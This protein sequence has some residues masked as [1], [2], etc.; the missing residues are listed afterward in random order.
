MPRIHAAAG[1]TRQ[2]FGLLRNYFGHLT[3][4]RAKRHRDNFNTISNCLPDAV[5][6]E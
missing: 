5:G 2:R 6:V 1:V 3:N 4:S